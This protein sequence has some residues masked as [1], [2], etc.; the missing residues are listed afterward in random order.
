MAHKV[1]NIIKI[2]GTLHNMSLIRTKSV[3]HHDYVAL[4][5]TITG[6]LLDGAHQ[7]SKILQNSVSKLQC[8]CSALLPRDCGV[9][10]RFNIRD[11]K[12]KYITLIQD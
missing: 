1:I 3:V 5:T 10:T 12:A 4:V 2:L 11:L 8:S 9:D 6:L 7:S